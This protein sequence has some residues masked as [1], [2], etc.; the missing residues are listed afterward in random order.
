MRLFLIQFLQNYLFNRIVYYQ[1]LF[2]GKAS[3]DPIRG[4]YGF[5]AI[6]PC[7]GATKFTMI[8]YY[9]SIRIIEEYVQVQV[10]NVSTGEYEGNVTENL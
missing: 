10:V 9:I 6:M 3:Q 1:Q 5:Y 8:G 2:G 4:I 7:T